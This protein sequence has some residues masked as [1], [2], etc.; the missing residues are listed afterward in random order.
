M[1]RTILATLSIAAGVA[2]AQTS[3]TSPQVGFMLDA[4]NS[5]RPVY[6]LA[7]NFLVGDPVA[8]G[9]V[10][11]EFSGSYGLLKTA[12]AVVVKDRTGAVSA[13]SDAPDGPALFAFARTG[14]PA[15]AYLP[16]TGALLAWKDGTFQAIFFDPS[17]LAA[18]AVHSIAAPD[19]DHA[20]LIVQRDDGLWDLRVL[21][22]TGEV[23]S[24]T[25]IGG[26]APPA[27]M[28]ATG[29]LVYTDGSGIVIRNAEGSERRVPAQLPVSFALAQMGDGWIQLQDLAGGEQFA[30]RIALNREQIYQL[31]EVGQ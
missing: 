3:L 22:A 7:G 10:S 8:V 23:D 12:N 27:L 18:N 16:R 28:L 11:A 31:P 21:L 13:N 2:C 9:V 15:L 20:A 25:A 5:V 17:A 30:V 26:V 19:S 29:E 14:E 1:T 24:Q 6:G 4:A